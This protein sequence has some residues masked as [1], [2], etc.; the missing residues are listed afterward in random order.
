M[1][2]IAATGARPLL[3]AI[4]IG[5]AAWKP[6]SAGARAIR[7]KMPPALERRILQKH[8]DTTKGAGQNSSILIFRSFFVA[9]VYVIDIYFPP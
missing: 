5:G 4:R 7:A 8:D 9:E 6:R 2:R 3:P 1:T